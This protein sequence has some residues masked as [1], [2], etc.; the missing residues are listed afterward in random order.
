MNP[1][2]SRSP[3]LLPS[4]IVLLLTSITFAACGGGSPSGPS[5]SSSGVVLSGSLLGQSSSSSLSA[6]FTALS[7]ATASLTGSV[8][9]S[10][11]GYPDLTARVDPGGSFTLRGLPSGSFSLTFTRDGVVLGSLTFAS[12][13]PNQEVDITVA[14]TAGSLVLVEERRDGIGHG[15]LEIEG[16]VGAI[17]LLSSTGDSRFSIDG[18]T[19][20]VRPGQTAIREGNQSRQ[21]SDLTVGRRVHVKG[22]WLPA[23]GGTQPVLASEIKIQDGLDD[24]DDDEPPS[25]SPSPT[26]RAA[27]LIEGGVPGRSVELEGKVLSGN[28]SSFRLAVDGERSSGPVDVLAGGA[29]LECSPKSGPGAPTPAQCSAS[30]VAG[31]K[32][33]VKGI[34][35][36]CSATAAQVS[37]SRVIVQK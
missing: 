5:P 4:F 18:R 25:P 8:T 13:L 28:A 16:Q 29:V 37:A 15:D 36:T 21:A 30:V 23:E 9:V 10:V 26:P 3:H 20:V 17:L 6:G 2:R 35:N 1:F 22:S 7:S 14:I 11:T 32:V 12:V 34:L 27:C 33:H 24:Q 19:V 31:V